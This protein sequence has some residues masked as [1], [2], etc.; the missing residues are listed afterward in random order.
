MSDDPVTDAADPLQ[1]NGYVY[2]AANPVTNS[3]PNGLRTCSGPED[4]GQGLGGTKEDYSHGNPFW[5]SGVDKKHSATNKKVC[6]GSCYRGKPIKAS[7]TPPGWTQPCYGGPLCTVPDTGTRPYT[8][9]PLVMPGVPDTGT[10][11]YTT[12]PLV[13]PGQVGTVKRTV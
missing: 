4:C 6:G 9:G 3:D 13:M 1:I 5:G 10:R 7:P 8:T 2:A 11:P 12:G